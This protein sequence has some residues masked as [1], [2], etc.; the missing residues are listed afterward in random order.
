MART[1]TAASA[2]RAAFV[3][4]LRTGR[5]VEVKYNP[6]HDPD[7]GRFTFAGSGRYV[8]ADGG[9]RRGG[10][11]F[12][13]GGAS[14]RWEPDPEPR[15][16][17]APRPSPAVP[18]RNARSA[19]SPPPRPQPLPRTTPETPARR[20][21]LPMPA[22][23]RRATHVPIISTTPPKPRDHVVRN[24]YRFE[25]DK[26][27]KRTGHV[28]G[29]IR[30]AGEVQR[31]RRAQ[32]DAGKPDRRAGDDG[33]HFIAARF[34]GPREWFNHFAQDANFNRGEYRKMEDHWA[35][36]IRRGERVFIDIS[37]DYEGRSRRPSRIIVTTVIGS[38]RIE[39]DFHNEKGGRKNGS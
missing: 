18:P 4:Y 14:G 21:T 32:A 31:S 25:V 6:W 38:K 8:P 17:V 35:Q 19:A 20:Q 28:I 34:G 11:S 23:D 39:H 15:G 26:D 10:G 2:D 33:G 3:L 27:V 1:D 5:R 9:V 22:S 12:G 7:D 36:A 30:M 16:K 13:G 24:G 29:E 37:A